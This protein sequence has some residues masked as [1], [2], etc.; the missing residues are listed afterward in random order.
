MTTPTKHHSRPR[1]T[2]L[3]APRRR[4][5]SPRKERLLGAAGGKRCALPAG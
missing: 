5:G 1:D 4:P 2:K 3:A